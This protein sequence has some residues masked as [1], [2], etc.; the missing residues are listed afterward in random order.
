MVGTTSTS[1]SMRRDVIP[2]YKLSIKYILFYIIIVILIVGATKCRTVIYYV[3][4]III[5][6]STIYNR[7]LTSR[8]IFNNL[9]PFQNSFKRHLDP[10]FTQMRI[11]AQYSINPITSNH[12]RLGIRT[13]CKSSLAVIS[14][15]TRFSHS[16]SKKDDCQ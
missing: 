13:I 12:D 15:H 11:V 6:L 7:I 3:H 8:E 4:I 16:L 5:F 9:Q 10:F 2:I 14:S 1:T